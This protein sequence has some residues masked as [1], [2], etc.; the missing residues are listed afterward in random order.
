VGRA[1]LALCWQGGGWKSWIPTE[2]A[3]LSEQAVHSERLLW[4]VPTPCVFLAVA[5]VVT[6]PLVCVTSHAATS[7]MLLLV[8]MRGHHELVPLKQPMKCT[9]MHSA[10]MAHFAET[11]HQWMKHNNQHLIHNTG[12]RKALMIVIL[13]FVHVPRATATH[14]SDADSASGGPEVGAVTPSYHADFRQAQNTIKQ[15]TQYIIQY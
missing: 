10:F 3:K 15:V 11:L 1:S 13:A 8:V 5:F 7:A 12:T 9:A 2:S 6:L 4:Y 14:S